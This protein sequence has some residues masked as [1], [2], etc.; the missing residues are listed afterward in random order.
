[1]KS[2]EIM[3]E[4]AELQLNGCATVRDLKLSCSKIPDCKGV[5]FV[6]R[7]RTDS[8]PVFKSQSPVLEHK[9]KSLSYSV[10]ELK[11]KWVEDTQIMYIGKTDSSLK[12][13]I[14]SYIRFGKGSDS[15][16]R[17]GRSIWQLPDVD[18]LIIGWRNLSSA[19]SA[20]AL[21]H[22]LLVEFSNAHCGKLPFA[23]RI[24]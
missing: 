18:N 23:N 2:N 11:S 15:P 22:Q 24:E 13:R 9:G 4:V 17:G 16:H 12:K 8:I 20:R 6:L 21:E 10:D 3:K 5:Y 19:E 14:S 7:E 1:M